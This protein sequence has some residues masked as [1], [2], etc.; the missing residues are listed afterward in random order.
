MKKRILIA[1]FAGAAVF[2][3][4]MAFAAS[5]DLTSD[6]L[7][8]GD[9][10]VGKCQVATLNV[11]YSTGFVPGSAG[12]PAVP[13]A[14]K[15]SQATVAPVDAACIGKKLSVAFTDSTGGVVFQSGAVNI[16]AAGPV[17]FP[18]APG[19]AASSFVD[20]HALINS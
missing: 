13:G 6:Q 12:P 16:T 10:A 15:V 9:Q 20:A 4:A 8:A 1:L 7:Q 17:D 14:Y 2:G 3:L 19:L 11:S 5:L 18:I